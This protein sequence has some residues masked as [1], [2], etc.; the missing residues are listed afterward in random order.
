MRRV[1]SRNYSETGRRKF[2]NENLMKA[3]NLCTSVRI[4]T[5]NATKM[6]T[7]ANGKQFMRNSKTA[8]IYF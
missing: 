1:K 3:T 6:K 5:S 2:L 4:L 7:T 8:F